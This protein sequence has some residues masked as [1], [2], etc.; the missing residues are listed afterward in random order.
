MN[1]KIQKYIDLFASVVFMAFMLH[2]F[3]LHPAYATVIT[4]FDDSYGSQI[5]YQD[6]NLIV[7]DKGVYS[8]RTKKL[9]IFQEDPNWEEEDFFTQQEK[10]C[11][12]DS[13]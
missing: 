7:T 11:E 1:F 5:L 9:I 3:A 8:T 10:Y 12:K 2:I 6:R 13:K 4:A